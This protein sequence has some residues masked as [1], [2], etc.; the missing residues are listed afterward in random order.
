MKNANLAY[1]TSVLLG[2]SYLIYL[3]TFS[4]CLLVKVIK[5]P[6]HCKVKLEV[7]D[8]LQR[9][10]G[11]PSTERYSCYKCTYWLTNLELSSFDGLPSDNGKMN[12]RLETVARSAK[13]GTS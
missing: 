5:V 1:W 10:G 3:L 2:F 9:P 12:Q 8:F 7:L 13:Y 11:G 4:Q 6:D